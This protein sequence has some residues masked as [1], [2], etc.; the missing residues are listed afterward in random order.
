[1]TIEE[2]TTISNCWLFSSLGVFVSFWREIFAH[3]LGDLAIVVK[4]QP[5]SPYE[6]HDAKV[7]LSHMNVIVPGY[8]SWNPYTPFGWHGLTHRMYVI[9]ICIVTLFENDFLLG[10]LQIF[11]RGVLISIKIAHLDRCAKLEKQWW[12]C[13][14]LNNNLFGQVRLRGSII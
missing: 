10:R 4:I 1:M 2:G 11:F 7:I 9:Y 3:F 12:E 8:S 13:L 5:P 6:G 14:T